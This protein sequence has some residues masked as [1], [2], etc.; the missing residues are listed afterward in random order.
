MRR[1][2]YRS[3]RIRIVTLCGSV[4]IYCVVGSLRAEPFMNLGFEDATIGTP[5]GH[6]VPASQALPDWTN[7][8]ER[9]A[10]AVAFG[11]TR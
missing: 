9:K 8:Y 10:S 4:V 6:S 7:S 5:A 11:T 3:L 2:E 1:S